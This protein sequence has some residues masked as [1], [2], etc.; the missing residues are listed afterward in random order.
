MFRVIGGAREEKD[1]A[2]VRMTGIDP[3]A[4]SGKIFS[5]EMI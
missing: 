4:E 1:C 3:F 5:E 2:D